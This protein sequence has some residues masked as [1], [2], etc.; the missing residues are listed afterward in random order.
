M[1]PILHP[2]WRKQPK[3]F[4][5]RMSNGSNITKKNYKRNYNMRWQAKKM[6]AKITYVAT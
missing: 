1:R 3:V 6:E 2:N 5:F 4:S